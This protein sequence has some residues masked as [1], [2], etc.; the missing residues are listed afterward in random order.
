MLKVKVPK[1]SVTAI[2]FSFVL[3]TNKGPFW[4]FPSLTE[5]TPLESISVLTSISLLISSIITSL[6]SNKELLLAPLA[7]SNFWLTLANSVASMFTEVISISDCFKIPVPTS[8][9]TRAVDWNVL[10]ST[11]PI[12]RA[13]V[14]GAISP[15]AAAT[16]CS[17]L[18]N[19]PITMPILESVGSIMSSSS[20]SF[21]KNVLVDSKYAVALLFRSTKYESN[22][23]LMASTLTPKPDWFAMPVIPLWL[24]EISSRLASRLL[25]PSVLILAIFWPVTARAWR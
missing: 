11:F 5:A 14:L 1:S 25:Y 13:T 6:L 10:A 22:E 24:A 16:A 23:R 4:D 15:G 18:K 12:S 3:P 19:L 21:C 7:A 8:S 2:R 20:S 9:T 17:E